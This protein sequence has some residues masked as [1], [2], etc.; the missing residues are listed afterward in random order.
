MCLRKKIHFVDILIDEFCNCL[1]DNQTNLEVE[2]IYEQIKID[3]VLHKKLKSDGWRFN[4]LKVEAEEIVALKVKGSSEIEGLIAYSKQADYLYVELVE[5][6]PKNIGLKGKYHGV[7]PH[8]FAIACE[9]SKK[10]GFDGVVCFRAKT[11]L[12]GHYYETLNAQ[13]YIW[14]NYLAIYEKDAKILIEKYIK[15]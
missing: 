12:I 4:W 1:V 2:T 14:P 11:N 6:N 7:G 8:L 5:S 9:K 10:I 15:T 13:I 3:K